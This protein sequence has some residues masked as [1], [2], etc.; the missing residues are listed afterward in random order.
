MGR[1]S[2]ITPK[3]FLDLASHETVRQILSRLA[4]EGKI[5]RLLRGV[6]EY[7]AFSKMLNAPAN[8]DPDAIAQAI[9]RAHGAG[10]PVKLL[11]T[12]EDDMRAGYYRPMYVHVLQAG[13][14]KGGTIMAWQ[15]RI[16]GQS[17]IGEGPMAAMVKNGIDP[18]SVEGASNLPY[19]IGHLRVELHTT[20]L[21][22]PVLYWRSVGSSHNAFVTE[23][24]FDEAARAAGKDPVALRGLML[25]DQERHIKV[26]NMAA[27]KAGWGTPLPA[28]RA[29]GVAV[30]QSFRTYVA[31]VAEVSRQ[32]AGFK[33]ERVVCAVD[34]GLA[35]NPN[36]VVSQIESGIIY[37]LSAA[38][39][40]AITL[41]DGVVEQS[42]FNDYPV[43]RMN[44]APKI[45]VYIVSSNEKPSGI[46]EPGVPP[47][48]PAVCNAIAA[49]TGKPVRALPLSSQGI[50][51]V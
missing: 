18:T 10:V 6:Y 11:W 32:G 12:R 7:P 30:H 51:I 16:V 3:D 36:I 29:R 13:L 1:G 35:V 39:C 37:G 4:K 15:H 25:G 48:M 50:K 41:K 17:I 21:G 28:G 8:P 19:A 45:E 47:I 34:C 24:F 22:V 46:G 44:E 9:A 43:L 27:Q 31:Q 40:G 33:V 38:C 42:N 23:C 5:R 26:L 49:L 14:D 2:V 20:N